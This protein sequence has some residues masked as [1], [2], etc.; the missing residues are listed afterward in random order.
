MP[1]LFHGYIARLNQRNRYLKLIK[2]KPLSSGRHKFFFAD[3]QFL[4]E[5]V[6]MALRSCTSFIHLRFNRSARVL[7]FTS[8]ALV[9]GPIKFSSHFHDFSKS[10]FDNFTS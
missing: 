4:E 9:L 8:P 6:K 5:K 7:H 10:V 2:N 1:L 3:K